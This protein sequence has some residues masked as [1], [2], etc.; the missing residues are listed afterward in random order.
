MPTPSTRTMGGSKE[1][2]KSSKMPSTTKGAAKVKSKSLVAKTSSK[3]NTRSTQRERLDD[4]L[5]SD[6]DD[7]EQVVDNGNEDNEEDLMEAV[8]EDEDNVK[9]KKKRESKPDTRTQEEIDADTRKKSARRN[10]KARR[11]G[12]RL[13]AKRAGYSINP[14]WASIDG[15]VD[16]AV[17]IS[18]PNEAIRACKWAPAVTD[19][20]AFGGFTEFEE[21]TA[22]SHESLPKS[23]ARVLHKNGEQ[24]L[25]RLTAQTVQSSMD[26][27]KTRATVSM[28]AAVTRPLKRVQKYSF[29]APQ[30]LVRYSQGAAKGLRLQYLDGESKDLEKEDALHKLQYKAAKEIAGQA[31]A[32]KDGK[33]VEYTEA[34]KKL[35]ELREQAAKKGLLA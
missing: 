30:G 18:T 1:K 34:R 26:Q 27:L 12:Y 25:R 33:L 5:G 31:S 3:R 29:V 16:V 32:L 15:S 4:P 14:E 11:R 20:S 13:I 22:L 6:D 24:Y 7:E 35:S 23:A 21:R 10:A 28:V 9:D 2:S 17:P 19:K 8:S